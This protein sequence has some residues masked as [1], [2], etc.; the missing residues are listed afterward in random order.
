LANK[1]RQIMEDI[2]FDRIQQVTYLF[3]S[4]VKII[5]QGKFNFEVICGELEAKLL[6]DFHTAQQEKD[7]DAMKVKIEIFFFMK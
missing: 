6:Q 7:F 2:D 3:I 5:F 1:M 4:E